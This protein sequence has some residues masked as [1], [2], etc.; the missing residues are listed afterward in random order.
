MRKILPFVKLSKSEK[1][2]VKESRKEIKNDEYISLSR[3]KNELGC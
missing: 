3:L 1:K 2:A